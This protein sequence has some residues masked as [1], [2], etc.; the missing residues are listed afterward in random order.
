[1]PSKIFRN[2]RNH[3]K[4]SPNSKFSYRNDV[5]ALMLLFICHGMQTCSI[6]SKA[7]SLWRIKGHFKITSV[8]SF[9]KYY[10]EYD[11]K[12][13]H[14]YYGRLHT[15]LSR[16]FYSCT[17]IMM[18]KQVWEERI[19]SAYTSILLFITKEVRTWTQAGQEVGSR[20]WK[21]VLYWLASPGLL[22]LLS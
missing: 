9:I 11:E 13:T 14:N 15:C 21:D 16:G 3:G 2:A 8:V 18:K 20:P 1:M 6:T 12:L 19:Y 10:E 5:N 17:N 7:F 22:I 4:I